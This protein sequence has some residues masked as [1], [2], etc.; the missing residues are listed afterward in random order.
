[1]NGERASSQALRSREYW[2][3]RPCKLKFPNWGRL[4]KLLTHRAERRA[5]AAEVHQGLREAV[6]PAVDGAL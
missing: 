1:M 3:R 5:G 2:S 4:A 6:D